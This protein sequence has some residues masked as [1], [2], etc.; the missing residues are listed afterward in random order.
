MPNTID[1]IGQALEKNPVDFADTFSQ[2]ISQ[3]AADAV[4]EKKVELAQSI[5]GDPETDTA[6][7]DSDDIDFDIDFDDLDDL[8]YGEDSDD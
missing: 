4:A 1:L 7:D 2:L 8:D 3:K 5:Y 6:D